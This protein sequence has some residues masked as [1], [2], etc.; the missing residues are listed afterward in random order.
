MHAC[1]RARVRLCVYMCVCPRTCVLKRV[2]WPR[3]GCEK[4][5]GTK[6]RSGGAAERAPAYKRTARLYPGQ[7]APACPL[8]RAC[9]GPSS[10]AL[11]R[12]ARATRRGA[13][14]TAA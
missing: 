3:G 6:P 1:L 13:T 8:L 4:L 12:S 9:K 10:Y 14:R 2:E 7:L 5:A 11:R